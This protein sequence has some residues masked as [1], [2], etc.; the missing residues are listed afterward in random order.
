VTVQFFAHLWSRSDAKK[1]ARITERH[2]EHLRAL[3]AEL[4]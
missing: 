3:Q 2:R 1:L 4:D